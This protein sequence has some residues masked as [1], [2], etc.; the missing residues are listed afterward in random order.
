MLIS[1]IALTGTDFS[2]GL[3]QLSGKTVF[4]YLPDLW[5]LLSM[6]YDPASKALVPTEAAD[7]LVAYI[8]YLKY[9]NHCKTK[10]GLTGVLAELRGSKLA[11]S[12]KLSLPS[13]ERILCTIKNVNWIL[14]YWTCEACPDPIQPQYGFRLERGVPCYAEG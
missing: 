9:K 3:P 14:A 10:Q 13:P 2:R 5:G 1:L 11:E 4:G 8:Y 7:R 12:T 6:V